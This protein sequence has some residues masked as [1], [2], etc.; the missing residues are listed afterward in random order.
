MNTSKHTSAILAMAGCALLWSTAGILI[1]MV[2]WPPLAIA[3]TRSLI[4]GL[5]ILLYLKKPK[6]TFSFAQMAAA[7]SYAAT[8]ILFVTANKLTTSANA[9]L[10]Q[11][12]CPV[13]VAILGALILKERVS[14]LDWAVIVVVIAGMVLFFLDELSTQG[15]IGN[16][17]ALLSGVTMAL[18]M[19]FMRMQ[20]EGSPLESLL[21]SHGITFLVAIPAIISAPI[22]TPKSTIGLGLLGVFQIGISGMLFA[23]G[24]KSITALESVLISTLEPVFNPVWVFLF[25]KELPGPNSLI[26]GIIILVAVTIRSIIDAVPHIPAARK[27]R[28]GR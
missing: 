13:Y 23:Y 1:K 20:K 10:L 18:F 14:P 19:V 16:I 11:Y 25:T 17:I 4:G 6:I 28:P 3:G 2:E 15:L 27:K 5:I 12:T 22:L 26:G 7:V 9:I 8:M 21:I 24:V